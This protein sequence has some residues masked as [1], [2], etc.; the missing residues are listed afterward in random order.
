MTIVFNA[1]ITC[2][3]ILWDMGWVYMFNTHNKHNIER[4]TYHNVAN[5]SKIAPLPHS[6]PQF[7]PQTHRHP[8]QF[9]TTT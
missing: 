5:N 7:S 3:A 4:I 1:S 2:L 6:S 9:I 8:L